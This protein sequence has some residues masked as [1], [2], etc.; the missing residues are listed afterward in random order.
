MKLKNMKTY[1][2]TKIFKRFIE[3][4]KFFTLILIFYIKK[5]DNSFLFYVNY[6]VFNNLTIN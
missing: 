2:N 3:Y 5:L 6:C 4:F 1:I